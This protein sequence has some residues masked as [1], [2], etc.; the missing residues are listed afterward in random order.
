MTFIEFE[1]I[2]IINIKSYVDNIKEMAKQIYPYFN[3]R[4]ALW[5]KLN[6][7]I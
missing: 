2:V 1:N 7:Y 4:M 5:E 3:N 6:T